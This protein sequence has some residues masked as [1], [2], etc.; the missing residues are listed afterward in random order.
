[1]GLA[2]AGLSTMASA[3]FSGNV[4]LTTDYVW[5]GISQTDQDPAIQGG[6][7]YEHESGFSIGTW[8]SNV[9]FGD[10]T[11]M[12][13]DV[14]GGYGTE[15]EGIGL[16]VGYIAYNYSNGDQWDF[17]EVNIGASYGIF[18]AMISTDLDDDIGTYYEAALDFEVGDGFG[19][20]LHIGEY[21]L[22]NA[23]DVT[24]WSIGVSKE[25]GGFGFG[26]TYHDTDEHSLGNIYEERVVFTVSKSL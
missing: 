13:L 11:N 25:Y 6:F 23:G 21:D 5:R 4:A 9:E 2:L 20:G 19:I 17:D 22:D 24:D 1:M 16:S 8:A 3:E 12:E 26:L 10:D 18:S 7:D 15:F 14:Y